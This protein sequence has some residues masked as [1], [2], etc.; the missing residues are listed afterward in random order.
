MSVYHVNGALEKPVWPTVLARHTVPC[1]AHGPN[2]AAVH[3]CD[4]DS[5]PSKPLHLLIFL[6][7]KFR[8]ASEFFLFQGG[9][10]TPEVCDNQTRRKG[11]KNITKGNFS[12]VMTAARKGRR[13]KKV[14]IDPDEQQRKEKTSLVQCV[15]PSATP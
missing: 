6:V 11:V 3:R 14:E 12:G 15:Q 4:R 7:H 8:A 2:H 9:A 10:H 1:T 5:D 13:K